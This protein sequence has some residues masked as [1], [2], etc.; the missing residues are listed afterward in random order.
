MSII[1]MHT[2]QLNS[3]RLEML[4]KKGMLLM[5]AV[6]LLVCVG[7]ASAQCSGDFDKNGMVNI[8]DFLLFVKVFGTSSGDATFNVL[9]DMDSSGDIGIPDFLLFVK[10]FG[11]TCDQPSSPPDTPSIRGWGLGVLYIELKW[12]E[13]AGVDGYRIQ[14]SVDDSL[15]T[16]DDPSVELAIGTLSFRVANLSPGQTVY[17]RVQSFVGAGANREES[18]WSDPVA[19]RT[20]G[21][22]RPQDAQDGEFTDSRGRTI[23]YRLYLDNS[24]STSEPRGV[25]VDVHGNNLGTQQD[26]LNYPSGYPQWVETGLAYAVVASPRSYSEGH[27]RHLLG[28]P[29]NAAG[30]RAWMFEDGRLLHE[31]LQSGFNGAL[32]VDHDAIVLRGASQGSVFL[33]TFVEQYAGLYGG[34]LWAKCGG[35]GGDSGD[36]P[37]IRRYSWP[38]WEPLFLWTPSSS[39]FVR[40]RFRVVVEA[41]TGDFLYSQALDSVKYYGETLGLDVQAYTDLPGGHCADGL[42]GTT[43]LEVVQWLLDGGR[44]VR[45]RIPREGDA[46]ADGIADEQDSDDDNDGAPDF[47]DALPLDARDWLD[48]DADGIGNFM[49]RDAD[50]D[51]VDNSSDPFTLDPNES[52]DTDGDGIGDNLDDDDD[53]DGIPD[54]EDRTLS[55]PPEGTPGLKRKRIHFAYSVASDVRRSQSA[56]LSSQKPSGIKYPS[57]QGDRQAYA[58]LKLGS[59]TRTGIPIMV[60]RFDQKERCEATLLP[61][62]CRDDSEYSGYWHEHFDKIYV[63]RNNNGDLTDDGQALVLGNSRRGSSAGSWRP[64]VSTDVTV[65]YVSGEKIPYR[66]RL[67]TPHNLGGSVGYMGASIWMGT[68]ESPQGDPVLV[69]TVDADADGLFDSEERDAV[70]IDV[71]RNGALDECLFDSDSRTRPGLLRP[72]ANFIL[73]GR[74]HR[75]EVSPS[76]REVEISEVR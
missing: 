3:E 64:G 70:C 36:V 73:D 41:T 48:T 7:Q 12:R 68:V 31:L 1:F 29:T 71:D 19:L 17:F 4:L 23:R 61:G 10:V 74:E 14:Y 56:R 37:F 22:Q 20:L 40:E 62:L 9:M 65:S 58:S 5:T 53:N 25:L 54:T 32:V 34:G 47:I 11:S 72:G 59:G 43:R 6:G 27:P 21:E 30:R 8:P 39:A 44:Q 55:P 67:W 51:G 16:D 49:D 38:D 66:I 69:A 52:V 2:P 46:D 75:V 45:T 42:G 24:W 28:F 50:G 18:A 57:P 15:F 60:D 26:I 76:G 63:D 33:P 35:V 13:V